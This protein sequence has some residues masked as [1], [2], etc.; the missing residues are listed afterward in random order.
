MCYAWWICNLIVMRSCWHRRF[1][2]LP[3]RP[4]ATW[5]VQFV[6]MRS[7]ASCHAHLLSRNP[8]RSSL[9]S[10]SETFVA[11]LFECWMR[12]N[13]VW[14]LQF[15]RNSLAVIGFLTGLQ[16]VHSRVGRSYEV[17]TRLGLGYLLM[18]ARN[19][20]LPFTIVKRI[21]YDS[22]PIAPSHVSETLCWFVY[23]YIPSSLTLRTR[24][25]WHF[26]VYINYC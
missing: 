1:S 26:W 14:M 17:E 19:Q 12:T 15:R 20:V 18:C 8:P 2:R 5:I 24:H 23:I 9:W 3:V 4:Q 21:S 10:Y 25:Y 6:A 11:N 13:P 22:R 7:Q 16:L